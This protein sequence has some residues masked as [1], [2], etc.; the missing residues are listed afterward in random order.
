MPP[1]HPL[2]R[3]GSLAEDWLKLAQEVEGS[4]KES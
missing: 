1:I 4:K 2:R 3:L